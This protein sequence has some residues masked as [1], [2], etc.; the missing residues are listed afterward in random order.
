[1]NVRNLLFCLVVVF[2]LSLVKA[3]VGGS[4]SFESLSL[5]ENARVLGI[6]GENVST[7]DYDVN[8]I[9]YNPA[10][11]NDKM[12]G[13]I[14]L[15]YLPFYADVK[16]ISTVG[17]FNSKKI[18][19]FGVGIQYLS[20]GKFTERDIN[21]VPLGEFNAGDITIT[22]SKSHEL[23]PIVIGGN[24]KFISSQL[25][26][27][28][29]SALAFDLGGMFKHPEHDLQLG[30]VFRNAGFI[31]GDYTD[32][33]NSS[34][35]F[36]LQLGGSYKPEHMPV[37]FSITATNLNVK[38]VQYLDPE[39][40]VITQPD[41]ESVSE[42]KKFSEQIFRR[43]IFGT[44]FV[45]SDNFH[46]RMGYNHQRRKELRLD[47]KSGGAGFSFGFMLKIKKIEFD[48]TKVYYHV[49]GG[50]NVI[51]MSLNIKESFGSKRII[52]DSEL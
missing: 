51:T 2:N 17:V 12:V 30:M 8:S 32:E 5:N 18:G 6:G 49:V 9:L 24:L 1:M 52:V 21:G 50:T 38:D 39:R 27:Y 25:A 42:E 47:E 37:R 43:I 36:N 20:Y 22:L 29:A 19:N 35:P 45:F 15:N 44:E 31:L 26:D 16:K 13:S 46:L 40:D 34:L 33:K 14:S 41:G 11:L 3:Q 23:G 4:G 10:S 48:Y 7:S 28:S